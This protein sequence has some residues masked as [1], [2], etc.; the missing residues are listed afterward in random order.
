MQSPGMNLVN[1]IF[2]G[3]LHHLPRRNFARFLIGLFFFYTFILR[4]CYT[5]GLVKFMQMDTRGRR[6][7]STAEMME[8]NFTFHM[9]HSA[10]AYLVEM[11]RVLDHSKLLSVNEYNS[12]LKDM[13]VDPWYNGAFLTSVGHLAYR[14]M[15]V[16]PHSFHHYAPESI[17]TI[18]I[19][20]YMHKESCLAV[21]FKEAITN[22]VNGGL[23]TKWAS[24]LINNQYLKQIVDESPVALSITQLMGC[25]ELWLLGLLMSFHVF[26][27]EVIVRCRFAEKFMER[28]KK[29]S[30]LKSN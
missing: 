11:P 12:K 24:L 3:S 28:V 2:G 27:M 20:I 15:A 17:Y 5:G 19:A 8:N 23:V 21:P 13:T 4:S 25:F 30:P 1:I 22:L 10:R 18:N 9:L 16:F 29:I 7:M 14:N 26:V 6:M